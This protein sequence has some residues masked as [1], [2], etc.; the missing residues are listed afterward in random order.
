VKNLIPPDL[1]IEHNYPDV[2]EARLRCG[3]FGKGL[4]Q[5]QVLAYWWV[6]VKSLV[7][8]RLEIV[9]EPRMPLV[10]GAV[11]IPA[12]GGTPT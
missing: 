5:T 12:Y 3:F 1:L 2:R 7:K 9:R 6:S 4:L 8:P 10:G 11:S